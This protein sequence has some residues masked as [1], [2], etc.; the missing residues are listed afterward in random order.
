MA[1]SWSGGEVKKDS[2]GEA[3]TGRLIAELTPPEVRNFLIPY[4]VDLLWGALFSPDSKVIE[5]EDSL[6]GI[7]LWDADTGRLVPSLQGHNSSLLPR[8]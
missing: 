2:F 8:V 5:T 7:E 4:Y 3:N 1:G 6:N